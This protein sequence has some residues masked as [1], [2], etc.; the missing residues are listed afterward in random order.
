LR[1][2]G[3]IIVF[4]ENRPNVKIPYEKVARITEGLS[5]LGIGYKV[6]VVEDSAFLQYNNE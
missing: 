1:A 2:K 5:K 6:R 3:D 4:S